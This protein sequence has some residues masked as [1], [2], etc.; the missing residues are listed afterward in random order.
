MPPP[1]SFAV[2]GDPIS[3]S[4]SPVLHQGFFEASGLTGTYTRQAVPPEG[5]PDFVAAVRAG[6]LPLNG[7]NVTIPHKEAILPLVDE[8]TPQAQAIGAVNTV[9]VDLTTRQLTGHNTDGTGYFRSLPAG[10]QAQ[11]P[12]L[13]VCLLGAGGSARAVASTLLAHQT[14]HLTLCVRTHAKGEALKEALTHL[15]PH[16]TIEVAP[17][18]TTSKAWTQ[19]LTRHGL[20]INTTPLGMSITP[21]VPTSPIPPEAFAQ[22]PHPLYVSD[23]I[24]KPLTTPLMTAAQ[25]SGHPTWNGLGMLFW[26]GAEAFEWWTGST[27]PLNHLTQRTFPEFQ[28]QA[29]LTL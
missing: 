19:L 7:F 17:W 16:A 15:A 22:L 12:T 27:L 9:R 26:Q 18:P 4:L 11:L 23:L 20:L 14:P 3:Q 10:V 29:A 28:H 6:E 2:I 5:L 13:S 24:Y 21:E 8:L 25:L 1:W